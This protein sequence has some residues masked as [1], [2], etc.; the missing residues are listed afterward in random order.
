MISVGL[1][2]FIA[3]FDI[4]GLTYIISLIRKNRLELK[5]ALSWIVVAIFALI[6]DIFP[7]LM[8]KLADFIGIA[9]PANMIFL[10]G[11]IFVLIILLSLTVAL[12]INAGSVKRLNQKIAILEKEIHDMYK[13]EKKKEDAD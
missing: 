12:S 10:F 3:V 6:M 9:L 11:F 8:E 7:G 5:Y 4:V 13:E 2:I 1:Q